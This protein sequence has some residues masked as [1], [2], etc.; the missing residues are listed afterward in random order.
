MNACTALA[1]VQSS[2][3]EMPNDR[4]EDAV[5]GGGDHDNPVLCDAIALLEEAGRRRRLLGRVE[6]VSGGERGTV[7]LKQR[8]SQGGAQLQNVAS[9]A[10]WEERGE[11][12]RREKPTLGD[13]KA[14]AGWHQMHLPQNQ[15]EIHSWHSH[16]RETT[17]IPGRSLET[18]RSYIS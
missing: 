2:P 12:S 13:G 4:T 6:E 9:S 16:P 7:D 5:H 14:F 15:G 3:T 17:G 1:D 8:R 10:S 18:K 11:F